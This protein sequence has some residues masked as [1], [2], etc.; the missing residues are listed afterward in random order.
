L[1]PS[2]ERESIGGAEPRNSLNAKLM[3]PSNDAT[4]YE[5]ASVPV[6]SSKKSFR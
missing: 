3:N 2:T 6:Y 1:R 5:D 4:D